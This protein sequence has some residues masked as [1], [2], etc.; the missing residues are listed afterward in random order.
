[1]LASTGAETGDVI[2]PDFL[3]KPEISNYEQLKSDAEAEKQKHLHQ[4]VEYDV[5][6]TGR[7]DVGFGDYFNLA[8]DEIIPAFTNPTESAGQ[9]KLVAKRIEYSI[10][11]PLNGKGGFLRRI[12]GVRRFV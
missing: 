3:E 8:D 12:R 7:F 11:K 4:R 1:M 6:T 2:Q 10:S 9:V 5:T